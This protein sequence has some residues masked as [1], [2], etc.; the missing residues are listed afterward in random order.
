[1]VAV[2]RTIADAARELKCHPESVRRRLVKAGVPGVYGHLFPV[3]E[4]QFQKI[5]AAMYPPPGDG[6]IVSANKTNKKVGRAVTTLVAR[7]SCPT[8]CPFRAGGGCYPDHDNNRRFWDRISRAGAHKSPVEL[9]REEADKI[10]ELPG[11]LHMRLHVAGDSP[12]TEG[13]R[14]I[15]AACGRYIERGWHRRDWAVQ[16]RE[17]MTR[18]SVWTYTHAWDRIT[19]ESWGPVSVLA[20]VQDP[21]DIRHAHLRGYA[22]AITL[23]EFPSDKTFTLPGY[24]DHKVIPCPAQTRGVTCTDC[25]LCFDDQRLLKNDLSIGFAVHG[26]GGNRAR[27]ALKGIR[28]PLETA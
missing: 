14:I 8:D 11:T 13:T 7:H 1:M 16:R 27:N 2:K 12:T 21:W 28:I 6:V 20:S 24:R 9:A 10:D 5:K 22:V 25:K 15:A 17:R 26:F 3:T 19:R 18:P 23:P 4:E